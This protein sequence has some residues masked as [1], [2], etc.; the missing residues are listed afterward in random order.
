MGI[1]NDT[2]VEGGIGLIA[3]RLSIHTNKKDKA[4]FII[5]ARRTYIDALVKPFI[6]K[7]ISFMEVVIIFTI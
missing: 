3:S 5:S 4:S 1:S 7:T 6:K 2:E